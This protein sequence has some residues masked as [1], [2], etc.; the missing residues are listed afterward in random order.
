MAFLSDK[1][2]E[3]IKNDLKEFIN[4]RLLDGFKNRRLQPV[5]SVDSINVEYD[6][7]T[8]ESDRDN[9]ILQPVKAVAR[10]W[11]SGREP[12]TESNNHLTLLISNPVVFS[13]DNN[14]K[15]YVLKDTDQI[16][17]INM[18]QD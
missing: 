12:G 13:F 16:V 11:V 8:D 10:V 17:I 2:S 14:E 5:V 3:K 1:E 9:I 7:N 15:A 4:G 18:T 6:I